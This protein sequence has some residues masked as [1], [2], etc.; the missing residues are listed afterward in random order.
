MAINVARAVQ[1]SKSAHAMLAPQAQASRAA[2]GLWSVE[3]RR[4]VFCAKAR[5]TV[6]SSVRGGP[7][8]SMASSTDAALGLLGEHRDCDSSI[9]SAATG[10]AGS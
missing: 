6:G 1:R 2:E 5:A 4:H 3:A 7:S 10:E 9:G 8:A